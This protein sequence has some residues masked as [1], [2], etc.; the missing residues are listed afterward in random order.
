MKGHKDST[1]K[2][3]PHSSSKGLKSGQILN[4]KEKIIDVHKESTRLCPSCKTRQPKGS[5]Y[6]GQCYHCD[7]AQHGS[8]STY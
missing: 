7:K 6:G 1:G 8:D 5:F 3:H 4:N 2:F